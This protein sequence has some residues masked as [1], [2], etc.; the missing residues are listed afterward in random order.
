NYKSEGQVRFHQKRRTDFMDIR[1]VSN[2]NGL[3]PTNIKIFI[4]RYNICKH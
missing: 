2:K 3:P 4:W 1:T